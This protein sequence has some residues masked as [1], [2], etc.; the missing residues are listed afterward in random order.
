MGK[1]R[2][3]RK[4]A[5]NP[6]AERV[7]AMRR[8]QQRRERR[9]KMVQW[10]VAAVVLL[11]IAGS[12]AAILIN[13]RR[14]RPSLDGVQSFQVGQGHVPGT[15]TYSATPPAGGEHNPVWLN[16]GVYDQPVPNENAVHSQEHGAVWVTYRPDLPADQ[17]QALKKQLT[18]TYLIVSPFPGLNAPVVVSAWGRQ[19]ALTAPDD[20]RLP[21]FI[22]EYRLG[23]NAPESGASC[24]G[25]TDGSGGAGTGMDQDGG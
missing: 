24:T 5:R 10:S 25:G 14:N 21:S 9:I 13:D 3:G 4:P 12:T 18:D 8:E 20:K 11:A 22:R 15:V 19:L 2:P 1:T 17:V 16:C 7:E 23:S 6:R